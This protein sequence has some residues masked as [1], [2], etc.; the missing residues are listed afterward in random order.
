MGKEK[1]QGFTGVCK[2]QLLDSDHAAVPRAENTLGIKP[3]EKSSVAQ[4]SYLPK[5]PIYY[6]F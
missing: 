3:L 6:V 4:V 1:I 2:S 5:H